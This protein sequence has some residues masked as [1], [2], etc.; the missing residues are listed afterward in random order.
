[1]KGSKNSK[2]VV[3]SERYPTAGDP[4]FTFVDNLLVQLKGLGVD[5]RVIS[6]QSASRRLIRA[7]S[8]R[9]WER[10]TEKGSFTVHQPFYVSRDLLPG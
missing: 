8:A 3:I 2:L 7:C 4:V 6:P 10:Q 9:K 1:M 5:I